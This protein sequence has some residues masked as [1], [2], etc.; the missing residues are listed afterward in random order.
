MTAAA[1]LIADRPLLRQEIDRV[2]LKDCAAKI[3]EQ[4][5]DLQSI[6]KEL[7]RAFWECLDQLN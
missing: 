2:L 4:K 1:E 6:P 5:T 3:G 7:R